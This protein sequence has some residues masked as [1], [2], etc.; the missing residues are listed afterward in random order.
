MRFRPE[1]G[2]PGEAA[3]ARLAAGAMSGSM[4][5]LF[6]FLAAVAASVL[7]AWLAALL[8][9]LLVGSY[10][11]QVYYLSTIGRHSP[12]RRL[13]TWQL[14]LVFHGVVFV[15]A[16]SVARNPAVFVLLLPE[17]VSALLHLLG[18]HHASKSLR[19]A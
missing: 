6:G 8:A 12:K 7:G 4:L 18:I 13:L 16:Y 14:S 11:V 5:L 17:G 19:G 3:I 10:L 15:A 1:P 9:A 2:T